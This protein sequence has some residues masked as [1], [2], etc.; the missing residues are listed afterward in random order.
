MHGLSVDGD[1]K[2]NQTDPAGF[3]AVLELDQGNTFM[4]M[5]AYTGMES[6]DSSSSLSNSMGEMGMKTGAIQVLI[7]GFPK[8]VRFYD[9]AE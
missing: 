8:W 9:S 7:N 3:N 4:A 6:F 1:A 2:I 5:Q